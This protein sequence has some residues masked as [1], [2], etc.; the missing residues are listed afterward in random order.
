LPGKS[1]STGGWELELA[2]GFVNS[3]CGSA[4]E[5]EGAD[6]FSH[7]KLEDSAGI[8]G[9]DPGGEASGFAAED[10]DV[11]GREGAIPDEL[12]AAFLDEPEIAVGEEA[13]EFLPTFDDLPIEVGPIVHS[14]PAEMF[15]VQAE[16]KR[17]DEPKLG[18]H[19]N[20][21][22]P[23][24]AGVLGNI[25]LVQNDMKDRFRHVRRMKFMEKSKQSR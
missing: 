7:G 8:T 20:A 9:Q 11:P 4:G 3:G 25:W 19:G 22:P 6:V 12:V 24:I 1:R 16:S 21:S 17:T 15:F 5:V 14:G 23:D 10:E 13:D 18:T 2:E